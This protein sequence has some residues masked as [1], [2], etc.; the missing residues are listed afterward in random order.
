MVNIKSKWGD[1][2]KETTAIIKRVNFSGKVLNVAAGD[3]RFNNE[4]LIYAD[5]VVA[6]DN[7]INELHKLKNR[8]PNNLIKKLSTNVVDVTKKLSYGDNSF[9][10]VFCT[11]FLHTF[12]D[13][14]LNKIMIELHRILKK[15]GK[16]VI[17]F[18]TDIRREKEDGGLITYEGE[19]N[20]ALDEAKQIFCKMSELFNLNFEYGKCHESDLYLNDIKYDFKCNFLVAYGSRK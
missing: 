11:G 20:Y 8:C 18:A 3:G 15:G 19:G 13:E 6:I 5:H 17:D 16:I 9:D 14:K 12:K 1:E 4:L 10:G 2:E 7:D